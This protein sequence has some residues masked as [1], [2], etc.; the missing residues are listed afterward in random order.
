MASDPLEPLKK[1]VEEWSDWDATSRDCAKQL[2]ALLPALRERIA[3]LK[4]TWE[5]WQ[6]RAT[7]AESSVAAAVQAERAACLRCCRNENGAL[8]VATPDIYWAIRSRGPLDALERAKEEARREGRIA[9]L[10]EA[11]ADC[12]AQRQKILGNP[13]DP[14]WTEHLAEVEGVL[15]QKYRAAEL[16]KEARDG[17]R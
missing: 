6:K 13:D 12:E 11:E 3:V 5:G 9:A 17:K 10:R 1:L 16:E 8:A 15:Q 2:A 14:S 7:L 4:R